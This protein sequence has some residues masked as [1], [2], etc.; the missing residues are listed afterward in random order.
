MAALPPSA[1]APT[2]LRPVLRQSRLRRLGGQSLGLV[3]TLTLILLLAASSLAVYLTAPQRGDEPTM[4]S[5]A[6]GA[7][8]TAGVAANASNPRVPTQPC[9]VVPRTFDEVMTVLA[10]PLEDLTTPPD[11]SR[12]GL[13]LPDGSPV[14][15]E[16]V[17][18]LAKL[19][20][21]YVNCPSV[22]Q[23]AALGTDDWIY[24]MFSTNA[25]QVGFPE[26]N[27]LNGEFIVQAWLHRDGID[28]R[29]G[30]AT[31]QPSE[32]VLGDLRQLNDSRIAGYLSRSY[33]LAADGTVTTGKEGY[34]VFAE[35]NGR[36]LI[37][38]FRAAPL[39]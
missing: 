21:T 4:M 17:A 3:A 34:V 24:R 35:V 12:L 19:T 32:Y 20:G 30:E 36:W 15:A 10:R 18:T 11:G 39:G 16:T 33:T 14:D 1:P 27:A 7:T 25:T 28:I 37:D 8:P 13:P 2:L 31:S 29:G 38:D 22:L 23:L 6:Y 9:D 5:A 26:N